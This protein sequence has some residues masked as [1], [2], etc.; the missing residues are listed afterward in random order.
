MRM[1]SYKKIL[2]GIALSSL[3]LGLCCEAGTVGRGLRH[4]IGNTVAAQ[5]W[6]ETLDKLGGY[7]SYAD[8]VPLLG[9]AHTIAGNNNDSCAPD[10]IARRI[11]I[12]LAAVYR[13][14]GVDINSFDNWLDNVEVDD[15]G[16]VG[17]GIDDLN[18]RFTKVPVAGL[19][20]CL[21]FALRLATLSEEEGRYRQQTL[22][23]IAV[24]LLTREQ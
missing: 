21:H 19:E 22:V 4:S 15:R 1:I 11:S 14:E 8:L 23:N 18:N 6:R 16:I 13:N 3:C 2:T 10:V 20:D 12:G 24:L 5:Q 7:G 9:A 17:F